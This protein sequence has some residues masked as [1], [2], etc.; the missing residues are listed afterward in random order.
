[1]FSG[2]NFFIVFT[3]KSKKTR[4]NF[5]QFHIGELI[6]TAVKERQIDMLRITNFFN[7]NQLEVFDMYTA[8]SLETEILLKWSKLLEYDFFRLYSQ[9]LILYAP[10]SAEVDNK[11]S[12]TTLP[13]FRKNIYTKEVINFVLEQ[14]STGQMSKK[15]VMNRYKIPKT[16]LYKWISKYTEVR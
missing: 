14:I 2:R 7:C 10:P 16:T 12:K 3:L 5:K 1:M 4:M 11:K 9:H 6:R 8:E 13:R 15:D